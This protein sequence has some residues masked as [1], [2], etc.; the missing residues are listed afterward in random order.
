SREGAFR[1]LENPAA[2]PERVTHAM[3]RATT[4]R[5]RGH[6]RVH[7]PLDATSLTLT[8]VAG[9][10]GFGAVGSWK[11]GSR[12]IHVMTAFAVAEDGCRL[13]ICGQQMWTREQRSKSS[14]TQRSGD[15]ESRET[16][17]WLDQLRDTHRAFAESVPECTPW[18]QLD[19]G[20]DCWPVLALAR[21]LDLL[22]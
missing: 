21:E 15:I 22:L 6:K 12:G 14:G 1:L 19:R 17:Y 20:G 4:E 10:K 5:C 16:R 2:R 3:T 9:K 13:G 8:D 18:Y 11:Q 7:V